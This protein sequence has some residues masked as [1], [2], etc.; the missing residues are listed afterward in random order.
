MFCILVI[1]LPLFLKKVKNT[2]LYRKGSVAERAF[3]MKILE[4]E[5][6]LFNKFCGLVVN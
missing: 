6:E 4:F 3:E 5:A 1:I 2:V